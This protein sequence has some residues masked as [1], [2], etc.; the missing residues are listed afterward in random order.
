MSSVATANG[1]RGT[2]YTGG[3]G[4][5]TKR[6]LKALD[7]AQIKTNAAVVRSAHSLFSH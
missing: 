5:R 3:K 7:V 4:K 2:P 1:G 6:E